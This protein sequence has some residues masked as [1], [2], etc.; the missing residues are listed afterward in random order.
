[1][2]PDRKNRLLIGALAAAAVLVVGY[3][4]YQATSP[5]AEPLIP[6]TTAP[7]A[8]TPAGATSG[9]P[10]L[11]IEAEPAF[12]ALRSEPAYQQLLVIAGP[13]KKVH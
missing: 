4:V 3:A 11:R 13:P 6:S 1:M 10:L 2:T 7:A 12:A 5:S 8:P 9:A